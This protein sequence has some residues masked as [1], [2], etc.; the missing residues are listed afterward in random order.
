MSSSILTASRDPRCRW[1][2]RQQRR[3]L[4]S[5]CW[6]KECARHRP[7]PGGAGPKAPQTTALRTLLSSSP[8]SRYLAPG[9]GINQLRAHLDG[10]IPAWSGFFDALDSPDRFDLL[11]QPTAGTAPTG[12]GPT[13][14]GAWLASVGYRRATRRVL[15]WRDLS[16][17]RPRGSA[18]PGG[19]AYAADHRC[20]G[21]HLENL[22]PSDR[23]V[24]QPDQ[25]GPGRP[26][27]CPYLH[28]PST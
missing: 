18:R 13:R 24:V 3:P 27:R 12:C 22:G 8:G 7:G 26:P 14:L 20:P 1:I 15:Y 10:F 17:A 25:P 28:Q 9:G 19:A 21:G 6:P 4:R 16:T 2:S 23:R 11:T 5:L